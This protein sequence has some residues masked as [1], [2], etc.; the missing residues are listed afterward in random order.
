M[1]VIAQFVTLVPRTV[2][3]RMLY[4]LL[5][6]QILVTQSKLFYISDDVFHVCLFD[7]LF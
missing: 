2:I 3:S 5:V 7:M 4:R 6:D 1:A